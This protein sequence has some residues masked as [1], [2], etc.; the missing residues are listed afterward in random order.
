MKR[1]VA[2]SVTDSGNDPYLL[3]S[4]D[5]AND[6]MIRYGA[7]NVDSRPMMI[8]APDGKV[9]VLSLRKPEAGR[10]RAAGH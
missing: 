8:T 1:V 6:A 7:L 9:L 4:F 10:R 2:G 3:E 5:T